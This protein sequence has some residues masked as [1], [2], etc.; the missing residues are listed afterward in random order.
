MG[1]EHIEER[2]LRHPQDRLVFIASVALNLAL[3]AGAVY[4]VA[5]GP[6]WLK[7]HPYLRK[8]VEHIRTLAIIAIFALPLAVLVRNERRVEI[9][10]NSIRLSTD[11]FGAIY[12]LIE[13]Q[14]RKL[15]VTV[16]PE[17]YLTNSGIREPAKAFSTWKRDYIVL[18]QSIVDPNLQAS[19]DALAFILGRELGRIRLGYT[20]LWT[21][22]LLTY[23]LRI[24]YLN[25]PIS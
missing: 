2:N 8:P 23:V 10:G 5:S 21:E 11:Q 16:V 20:N 18:S 7:S 25:I 24:P 22:I 17:V 12:D 19:G 15:G 14:C 13:S 9:R 6:D 3:M 1:S 4:L